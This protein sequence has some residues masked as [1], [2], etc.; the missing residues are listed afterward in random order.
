GALTVVP[1]ETDVHLAQASARHGAR[2]RVHE[3]GELLHLRL[4]TRDEPIEY[5]E[6]A[7]LIYRDRRGPLVRAE[8]R[9][10]IAHDV[11]WVVVLEGGLDRE[12][13][14]AGIG[15]EDAIDVPRGEPAPERNAADA[16]HRVDRDAGLAFERGEPLQRDEREE[17]R[18][19]VA[20]VESRIGAR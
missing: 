10:P 20:V 16:D 3:R 17:H 7:A 18:R 6:R 5:L 9:D 1:E 15:R 13:L 8:L 2:D 4:I 14:H 12:G 11:R 19:E